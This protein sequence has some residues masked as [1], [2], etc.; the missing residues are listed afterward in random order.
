MLA[1]AFG[2]LG[3]HGKAVLAA[4]IFLGL[5]LP[6]LAELLRPLLTPSVVALLA[7]TF[8]RMDWATV[9]GH[10]RRPL[11]A[12]LLIVW[13]LIASPALVALATRIAGLP[14]G[15]AEAMLLWAAS[16][17][18][19]AAPSIAVLLGLDGALALVGT[20]VAT[21]AMLLTLPP[22]VLLLAG[23]DLGLDPGQLLLRLALLTFGALAMALAVRRLAGSAAIA[24]HPERI[25]GAIVLTLL[26]FAIAAMDGITAEA[27]AE[28]LRV[29]G[30]IAAAFAANLSFQALGAAAFARLPRRT[31]LALGITSGNRN[32]AILVGSLGASVPPDVFLYFAVGQLPIYL[33]PGLLAPIYRRLAGTQPRR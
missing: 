13:L 23:I 20:A 2:W 1:G 15:L 6:P 3:R 26:L 7:L 33:L 22:L 14:A 25:D 30:F 11:P 21:F 9:A 10:L 27:F 17:P 19:I 5:A 31:A 24:A 4:G 32:L 8:L 16:P 29:A 28:P 12:F 18:L